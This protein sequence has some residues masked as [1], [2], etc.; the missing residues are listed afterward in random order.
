MSVITEIKYLSKHD[1]SR[2]EGGRK[3]SWTCFFLFYTVAP[4]VRA[5]GGKIST[6][7]LSVG[8]ELLSGHFPCVAF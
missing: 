5:E 3:T 4:N 2:K 8:F 6:T 1:A 7:Y